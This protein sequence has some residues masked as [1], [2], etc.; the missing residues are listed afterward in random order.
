MKLF[1]KGQYTKVVSFAAI[2]FD[3][4]PKPISTQ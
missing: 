3:K 2:R 1:L 4:D